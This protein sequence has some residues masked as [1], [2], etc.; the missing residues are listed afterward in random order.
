[1]SALVSAKKPENLN[2]V[3]TETQSNAMKPVPDAIEM[4][5]NWVDFNTKKLVEQGFS[6]W[7]NIDAIHE[8]SNKNAEEFYKLYGIEPLELPKELTKTSADEWLASELIRAAENSEEVG[9][10]LR[11]L[12]ELSEQVSSMENLNETDVH[13]YKQFIL[14]YQRMAEYCNMQFGGE[15]HMNSIIRSTFFRSWWKRWGKCLFG[16][17]GG[18][19]TGGLAGC[20][21]G[22][23]VGAA[24]G[25]LAA[26]PGVGTAG[27]AVIG[28]AGGSFIGGI[29]GAMAGA[30]AACD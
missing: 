1:M 16:I 29:G 12:Q 18:G 2:S 13:A 23:A 21:T 3:K 7:T 6:D 8:Q 28:C 19:I 30:A 11:N 22:A 4:Y 26:S 15:I 10:Y 24:V 14:L 9:D 25:T 17:V 20:G 5:V 27:G